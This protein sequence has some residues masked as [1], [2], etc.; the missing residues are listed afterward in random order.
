MVPGMENTA[1]TTRIRVD[2][3]WARAFNQTRALGVEPR[4]ETWEGTV[5][6]DDL[7][8]IFRFF[9]RVEEGDG[10]RLAEIGFDL[11]SMSSGDVVTFLDT[12]EQ[13]ICKPMGWEKA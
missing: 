12:G 10:E 5:A 2:S 11:P 6:T 3:H 1:T 7:E 9:N 8:E 13:W 4:N